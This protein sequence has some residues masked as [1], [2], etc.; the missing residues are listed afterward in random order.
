[1]STQHPPSLPTQQMTVSLP[2]APAAQ[3]RLNLNNLPPQ[4][5]VVENCKNNTNYQ[6]KKH[7][8]SQCNFRSIHKWIIKRHF[9]TQHAAK[10]SKSN[11][12][13][14]STPSVTTAKIISS[15]SGVADNELGG[16]LNYLTQGNILSSDKKTLFDLRLIHNWKIYLTG[17]SRT[18]KTQLVFEL[19]KNIQ[20]I[21]Q[22]PP[23]KLLWVYSTWQDGYNSMKNIVHYFIEDDLNLQRNIE[24]L[25]QNKQERVC[26]V[27]DDC[28]NSPNLKYFM[29]LF[30]VYGR[31]NNMSL[32]FITQ[33]FFGDANI[34]KISQNCDYLVIMKNRRN[35]QQV[36]TLAQ[37]INIDSRQLLKIYEAATRADPFSY[38]FIDLTPAGP[39]ELQF[40]SHLFSQSGVVRVYVVDDDSVS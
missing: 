34:T 18:G 12:L 28:M 30:T 1:M 33:K 29:H 21:S 23:T 38:L 3:Q 13:S 24:T 17:A 36:K 39:P 25:T 7:K 6:L 14:T 2:A 37:Q 32:I 20:N 15:A 40:R 27:L 10:N 22:H 9:S 35:T 11:M 8:C 31:H 5:I 19:L 4:T 26:L 16:R